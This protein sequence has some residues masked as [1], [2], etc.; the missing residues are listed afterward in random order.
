MF[1]GG[2]LSVTFTTFETLPITAN[3]TGWIRICMDNTV[4]SGEQTD[5]NPTLKPC[6]IFTHRSHAYLHEMA[7]SMAL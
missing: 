3:W 7:L 1:E 2:S 5:Q 4:L 6:S